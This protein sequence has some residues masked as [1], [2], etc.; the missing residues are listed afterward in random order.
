VSRLTR[1]DTFSARSRW[2][3]RSLFIPRKALSAKIVVA[4]T[5]RNPAKI[6]DLIFVY[7]RPYRPSTYECEIN[8]KGYKVI[9]MKL[10]EFRVLRD[11][12]PG[13]RK[14]RAKNRAGSLSPALYCWVISAISDIVSAAA[15]SPHSGRSTPCSSS[16]LRPACRRPE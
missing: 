14:R 1:S 16:S 10:S 4:N 5:I 13:G 6:I 8:E 9:E 15:F 3:G 7:P 11:E 12:L 2:C